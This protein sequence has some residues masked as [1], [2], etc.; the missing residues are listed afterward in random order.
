[1]APK[2]EAAQASHGS[3]ESSEGAHVLGGRRSLSESAHTRAMGRRWADP[4][5]D[6][7]ACDEECRA[8][9]RRRYQTR[10]T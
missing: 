9:Y 3:V 8:K 6:V 7:G 4:E 2:R 1:M 10:H 5:N